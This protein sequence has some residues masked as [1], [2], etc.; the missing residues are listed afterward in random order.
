MT[1]PDPFR[2]V[3]GDDIGPTGAAR[4][5]TGLALLVTLLGLGVLAAAVIGLA[6]VALWAMFTAALG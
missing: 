2:P 1:D 3:L 5:R 6:I 4:A